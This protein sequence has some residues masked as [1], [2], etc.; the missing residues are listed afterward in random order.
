MET[1]LPLIALENRS[2]ESAF[3]FTCEC[4]KENFI[5]IG[6]S[7]TEDWRC[8][9]CNKYLATVVGKLDK[10]PCDKA[11]PADIAEA[12]RQLQE[13]ANIEGLTI[14]RICPLCGSNA[15]VKMVDKYECCNCHFRK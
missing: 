14:G 13:A 3:G 4:G 2:E 10:S 6:L 15:S 1:N 7:T 8:W 12:Q 11:S 5:N 9:H